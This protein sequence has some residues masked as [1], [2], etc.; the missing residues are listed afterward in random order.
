MAHVRKQIRDAVVTALTGL[1]TTGNSVH[2]TRVFPIERLK[3]PALVIYT[4]SEA[5]EFDTLHI[6]R[7]INR[8]LEVGV[9]AYVSGSNPHDDELDI[10]AVDIEEALAADVTLGGLAKDLQVTAFEADFTGDGEQIVGIG[11]FTV[12]VQY[13]T[14]ENNVETAA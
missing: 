6:P 7:S 3:L 10:I 8:V 14:L 11:R 1:P 12:E 2:A 9:E 5:V 4:K 13:R